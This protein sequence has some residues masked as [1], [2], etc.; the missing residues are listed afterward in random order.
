M[1]TLDRKMLK[2]DQQPND[3]QYYNPEDLQLD[4]DDSVFVLPDWCNKDTKCSLFST[5]RAVG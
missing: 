3:I 5:C 2:I 1:E 4:V